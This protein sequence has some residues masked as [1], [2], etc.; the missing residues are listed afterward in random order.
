[1]VFQFAIIVINMLSLRIAVAMQ[2]TLINKEQHG[3][4]APSPTERGLNVSRNAPD[5]EGSESAPCHGTLPYKNGTFCSC[6]PILGIY[7]AAATDVPIKKAQTLMSN[8]LHT[9]W[10]L[11]HT[12]SLAEPQWPSLAPFTRR[13]VQ[14]V[15][16]E[17]GLWL[18]STMALLYSCQHRI[19]AVKW[20]LPECPKLFTFNQAYLLHP[21]LAFHSTAILNYVV[22]GNWCKSDEIDANWWITV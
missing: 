1:M 11:T 12:C 13:R 21:L 4:R 19:V 2:T 5:E 16:L 22:V 7:S 10:D 14:H 9:A 18:C 15:G 20:Q 8:G 6:F 3:I 17:G